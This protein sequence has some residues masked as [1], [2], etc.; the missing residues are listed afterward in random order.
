MNFRHRFTVLLS[1]LSLGLGVSLATSSALAAP[2]PPRPHLPPPEAPQFEASS[3]ILLDY[4]SGQILAERNPDEQADPASITKLMTAYI[5]FS[6]L[7]QGN[8]SMSD[9][10]TISNKAWKAEGSRMFVEVNTQVSV[11]DLIHGVIIQSGNDASIALA[12]HLA[13]GED[14]FATWM[15]QHAERLGMTQTFYTN[16]TGLTDETHKSTARD[17]ATLVSAV[18]RDFPEYYAFYSEKEFTYGGITQANRNNLLWRDSSV[19]GVKTGHTKAAGYCLASSAK[20]DGMRLIS[21]VLG[22]PSARDRINSSEALLNY[23]FRFFESVPVGTKGE[24]LANAKIWKSAGENVQLGPKA[25]SWVSVPRGR[26]KDITLTPQLDQRLMAPVTV[27][28]ELGS[29]DVNLDGKTLR[30]VPL[31]ALQDMPLGSLWQRLRDQIM[32]FIKR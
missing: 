21:V 31:V 9:M 23:G 3:Y 11:S 32:L 12:E 30:S 22:T 20:R 6:E 17:I 8:I 7:Q 24:A 1:C 5:V 29:M 15:N 19:D 27:G 16:A 2:P 25:S 14:S 26:A 4:N 28:Q 18:V 13:G 10:V